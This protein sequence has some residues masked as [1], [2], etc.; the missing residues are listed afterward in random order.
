[1]NTEHLI[2]SR[3]RGDYSAYYLFRLPDIPQLRRDIQ[4]DLTK[5]S[6]LVLAH[7]S[8]FYAGRSPLRNFM[9]L[10]ADPAY[11]EMLQHITATPARFP[12][13]LE[14]ERI[15]E[16]RLR[17][18]RDLCSAHG[19]QFIFLLAPGFGPGEAPLVTAGVRSQ[20]DVM[21]P[22]HLNALSQDKFRD[23]FHL[24]AAGAG[25]FT[26]KFARMLKPRLSHR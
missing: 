18:L 12:P 7:F 16:A 3:I 24:N 17:A 21:V 6:G 13:D 10:R 22:I 4:Y 11:A 26:D 25:L 20:T 19:A 2:T 23:G 15:A 1:M 8:M 9:L 5:T 14:I